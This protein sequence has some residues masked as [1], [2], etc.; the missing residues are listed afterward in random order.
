MDTRALRIAAFAALI[1]S[2]AACGG[3]DDSSTSS[4]GASAAVNQ[5]V[6]GIWEGTNTEN[7]VTVQTTALVSPDGRYYEYSL[8]TSN[9]CAA[10]GTGT[11]SSSGDEVSGNVIGGLVS[12]STILSVQ[13]GC[14]YSDGSTWGTGTLSGTVSAGQTLSLTSTF[15]TTNGTTNSNSTPVTL[16]FNLLYNETSSLSKIAGNWI[17][18]TSIVT[19]IN[20]DGTVFSQ[21]PDTGC[22]VNGQISIIDPSY[23]VYSES[24]TY[25]DCTGPEAV[26]NGQ[27]ATGL[28]TLNDSVSPV[29]LE[30]GGSVTLSAGE[31]VIVVFSATAD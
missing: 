10:V 25:A 11:L 1:L 18:V 21:D 27:T 9:D 6:G 7:G 24:A 28:L 23:N 17:G 5:S 29:A 15:T 31:I 19:T 4:S 2:L 22:V 20:S 14:V 3:A 12:F 8:N 13:T 30:G 26:L 16:N